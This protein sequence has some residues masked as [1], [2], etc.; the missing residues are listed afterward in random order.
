M[1]RKCLSILQ[2]GAFLYLINPGFLSSSSL[3]LSQPP[4]YGHPAAAG[5]KFVSRWESEEGGGVIL[6]RVSLSPA[7]GGLGWE[8]ANR[9][10]GRRCC[11]SLVR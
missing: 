1:P 3:S 10:D 2:R 4:E 11:L 5:T 6:D 9:M 7:D 8:A